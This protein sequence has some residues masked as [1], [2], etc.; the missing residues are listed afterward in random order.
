MSQIP[1]VKIIV[2]YGVSGADDVCVL[3]ALDRAHELKLDI[4]GQT[5]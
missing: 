1:G 3:H 5:G 2:L 4:I